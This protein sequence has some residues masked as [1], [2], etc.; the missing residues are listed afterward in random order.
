MTGIFPRVNTCIN[1]LISAGLIPCSLL[2]K[3][4]SQTLGVCHSRML[5]SGIQARPELDPPIKTFGG[6]ALRQI[7]IA[8]F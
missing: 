5:L 7:L 6:D 4:Y 2:R 3:S 1:V 8:M